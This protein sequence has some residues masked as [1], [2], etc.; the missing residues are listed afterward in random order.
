MIASPLECEY[1]LR[2]QLMCGQPVYGNSPYCILHIELPPDVTDPLYNKIKRAKDDKIKEIM[3]NGIMQNGDFD[4]EGAILPAINLSNY[5][6]LGK[7]VRFTDAIIK[8]DLSLGGLEI[9]GNLVFTNAIICG[10]AAFNKI[11]IH[12]AF[13]EDA[14]IC[15]D[16]DF[17]MAT[18]GRKEK[19]EKNWTEGI[20]RFSRVKLGRDALFDKVT[21]FKEA[22]FSQASIGRYVSFGS[23]LDDN[24]AQIQG[25]VIF[26]GATIGDSVNFS[27]RFIENCPHC[28]GKAYNT[29][30]FMDFGGAKI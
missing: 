22:D 12:N 17:N 13:F 7:Q 30:G 15:K 9:N 3:Q 6:K 10:R 11:T 20:A 25:N 5:R 23:Y 16:L 29:D 21:I 4:F 14:E 24:V 18:I 8:G 28:I 19:V 26:D 2:R 27:K 1:I